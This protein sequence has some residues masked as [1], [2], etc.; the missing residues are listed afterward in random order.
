M[1]TILE[2]VYFGVGMD[3]ALIAGFIAVLPDNYY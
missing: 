3:A 2:T 1:K